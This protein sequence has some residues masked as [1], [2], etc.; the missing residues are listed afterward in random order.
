MSAPVST[1]EKRIK[2]IK[3]FGSNA[4]E[5]AITAAV[6]RIGVEH[7]LTDEQLDEIVEQQARDAMSTTR[8]VIRNRNEIKAEL[9]RYRNDEAA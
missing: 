8:R 6:Y 4:L 2:F 5:K 9:A 3:S 1:R 7:F